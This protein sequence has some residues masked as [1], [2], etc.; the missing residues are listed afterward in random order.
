MMA[1]RKRPTSS[2]PYA[3]RAIKHEGQSASS[4]PVSE[5]PMD[6]DT[7]RRVAIRADV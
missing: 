2:F 7:Y 1:D 5:R 3:A 6:L 4:P